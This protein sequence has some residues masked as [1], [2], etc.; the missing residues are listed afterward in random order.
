MPK[1]WLPNFEEVTLPDDPCFESAFARRAKRYASRALFLPS[2]GDLLLSPAL[3]EPAFLRYVSE[4]GGFPDTSWVLPVREWVE[5]YSLVGSIFEDQSLLDRLRRLGEDWILEPY[6]ESPR[7]L[8][9]SQQLGIPTG[10]SRPEQ[11]REGLV[12]RL[13]DK[14]FF[15]ELM[16]ELGVPAVPSIL[17]RSGTELEAGIL[18]MGHYERLMLKKT[19]AGGGLG[20][21]VGTPEALRQIAPDWFHGAVLVEPF[22]DLVETIGSLVLI[23]EEGPEKRVWTDRQ[24][25]R[26]GKWTGF[27]Y[28]HPSRETCRPIVAWSRRIAQKVHFLGGRGELDL[29]WGVLRDGTILALEANFRH[30]G[31]GSLLHLAQRLFREER[32]IAYREDLPLGEKDFDSFLPWLEERMPVLHG[33][34]SGVV[35]VMPPSGGEGALA[36][37]GRDPAECERL[38]ERLTDVL[39]DCC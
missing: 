30:N 23:G 28:P 24:L 20:N 34:G 38:E 35:V 4:L 29:D 6:I 8:Q 17:A 9:L 27:R 3:P 21:L 39:R 25:I 12:E 11:V 5:P 2:P 1:L 16:R 26:E 13:N 7:V 36:L 22:L 14:G 10:R 19:R 18:R 31:F 32:S 37:F 33:S 15:K